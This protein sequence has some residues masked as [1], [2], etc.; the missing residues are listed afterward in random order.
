MKVWNVLVKGVGQML[1]KNYIEGRG[2]GLEEV[3]SNSPRSNVLMP[4]LSWC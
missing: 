1:T 2:S 3:I 4:K